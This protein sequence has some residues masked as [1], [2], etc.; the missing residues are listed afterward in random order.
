MDL[1]V[2]G[3]FTVCIFSIIFGSVSGKIF[4]EK[5]TDVKAGLC[6]VRAEQK[7]FTQL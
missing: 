6:H 1:S 3:K 5:Q 7:V 4:G 2:K